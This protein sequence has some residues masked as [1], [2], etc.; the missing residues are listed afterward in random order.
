MCAAR[1]AEGM[2]SW[3]AGSSAGSGTSPLLQIPERSGCGKKCMLGIGLG[4]NHGALYWILWKF[5]ER[6]HTPEIHP[7]SAGDANKF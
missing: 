3:G 4:K 1:E 6:F 5:P 2:R 7:S